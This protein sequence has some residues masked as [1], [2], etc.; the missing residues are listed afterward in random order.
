MHIYIEYGIIIAIF[1]S[2]MSRLVSAI[3]FGWHMIISR[4]CQANLLAGAAATTVMPKLSKLGGALTTTTSDAF[5]A[6]LADGGENNTDDDDGGRPRM[7]QFPRWDGSAEGESAGCS[8][9]L[10]K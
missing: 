3:P 1:N 4:Y 2:L 8:E 7:L 6:A 10:I 5:Q 9:A